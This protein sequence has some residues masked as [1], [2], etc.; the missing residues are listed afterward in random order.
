M[1]IRCWSEWAR[2][3]RTLY[4]MEFVMVCCRRCFGIEV[5]SSVRELKGFMRHEHGMAYCGAI[6]LNDI[7]RPR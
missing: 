6:E 3:K 5:L 1:P 7:L 2:E 4:D